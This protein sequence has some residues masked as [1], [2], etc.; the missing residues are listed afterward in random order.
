M[1]ITFL[2]DLKRGTTNVTLFS[3]PQSPFP[4]YLLRLS[5]CLFV[6]EDCVQIVEVACSPIFRRRML[7]QVYLY[8]SITQ[9]YRQ[10]RKLYTGKECIHEL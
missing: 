7:L 4:R 1:Q 10:V 5:L 8:L 3:F 9:K 2:H 6:G